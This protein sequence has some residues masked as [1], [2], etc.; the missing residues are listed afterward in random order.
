M[1]PFKVETKDITCGYTFDYLMKAGDPVVAPYP[2]NEAIGATPPAEIF[3]RNGDPDQNCYWKDHKGQSWAISGAGQSIEIASAS[4]VDEN[5]DTDHVDYEIKLQSATMIHSD[6]YIIKVND[7]RGFMGRMSF[8]VGSADSVQKN[9]AVYVNGNSIPELGATSFTVTL[10]QGADNLNASHFKLFHFKSSAYIT[11]NYWYPIQPSFWLNPETPGDNTGKIGFSVPWL[12]NGV[13]RSNNNFPQDMVNSPKAITVKYNVVWPE[14]VPVLKAGETLTFPGG[15]YRA[16]NTSAPGLPG[17]L[18][19]ASGQLVYDTLNPTMASEPLFQKYLVRVIP[20]L[21]ERKVNLSLEDFPQDLQPA[22]KRVNVIMNR[23]YFKELH[24]GLKKRI[25][26][27][28]TTETLCMK[29]FIND[30][31]LGDDTLTAS[32]P[33]VYVLQP[34]IL[35]ERE[36]NIIQKLEG[37]NTPFKN[38]VDTL[39]ELSNNP[40]QLEDKDYS[41]GL[42][43]YKNCVER[44]ISDHPKKAKYIKD[45]FNAWLG[46]DIENDDTRVIP[47]VSYGP[48]LSVVPNAALLDPDDETFKTFTSGYITL[49]ENNH[50]DLGALPISLHIV[51]VVKEKVRGAIKVVCLFQ[52]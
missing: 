52:Y 26:Y 23:W 46:S 32:P 36:K 49:A 15:E 35:T 21:I 45:M 31:T 48:G 25:Y 47:K 17:V 13:I 6:P 24:A 29:G 37:A 38:A 12:P 9:S 33:S 41:A 5:T 20:G 40:T 50:P 14:D 42:E 22:S 10:K 7:N 43:L 28:P 3:G 34:N 44:M 27:D 8:T 39:Y 1:H 11:V 2:L 16:D 30:K 18:G 19:W 4:V 51:K